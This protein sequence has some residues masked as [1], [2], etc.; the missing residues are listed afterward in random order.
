MKPK[1]REVEHI[2]YGPGVCVSQ[3]ERDG[4]ASTYFYCGGGTK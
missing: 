4:G 1:L 2:T 3:R